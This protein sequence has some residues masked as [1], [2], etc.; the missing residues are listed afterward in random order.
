LYR[1]NTGTGVAKNKLV[2]FGGRRGN[3]MTNEVQIFNTDSSKWITPAVKGTC[4]HRECHSSCALREKVYVMGG[5]SEEG[6]LTSDLWLLDFD[7]MQWT[8]VSTYGQVWFALFTTLFCNQN[9]K[10][11]WSM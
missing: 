11:V 6:D 9:T 10:P 1:Y 8:T 3:A 7:T 4:T 2:T 5:I